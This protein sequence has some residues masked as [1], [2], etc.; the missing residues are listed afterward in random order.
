[1][2]LTNQNCLLF[3]AVVG[4]GATTQLANAGGISAHKAFYE[5]RLGDRVQNSNIVNVVGRSA[6]VVERDCDGW[7]SVEDYMI[8]FIN[9]NGGSDRILSHF[10][11]W[12]AD[13]G[14]SCAPQSMNHQTKKAI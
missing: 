12:E 3:L 6:F 13:S 2:K 10:E 5:M 7:V 9:D 11:S 8:E 14:R 4:F 1:M